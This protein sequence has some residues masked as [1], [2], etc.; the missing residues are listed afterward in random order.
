MAD[1]LPVWSTRSRPFVIQG[2]YILVGNGNGNGNGIGECG[3]TALH[4]PH[5]DFNDDILGT[6]IRYW[7]TL[8]EQ[9]LAK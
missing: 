6:G 9:Q 8:V 2:C 3:G 7:Q 5:Y 1:I 4:N